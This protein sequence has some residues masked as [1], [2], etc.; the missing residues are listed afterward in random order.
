MSRK[1][2]YISLI[3]ILVEDSLYIYIYIYYFWSK[4][5]QKK[6]MNEERYLQKNIFI[7]GMVHQKLLEFKIKIFP[8][9]FSTSLNTFQITN[10]ILHI[11]NN[12][13][14]SSKVLF[15]LFI[16]KLWQIIQYPICIIKGCL[17]FCPS[18]VVHA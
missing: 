13:T 16:A 1:L 5:K 2:K 3:I 11:P 12:K 17:H 14:P 18:F 8:R 10:K 4:L 6:Q 7:A 9:K 15:S